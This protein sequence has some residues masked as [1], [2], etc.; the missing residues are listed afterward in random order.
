MS[1]AG[2]A[3]HISNCFASAGSRV[4]LCVYTGFLWYLRTYI[5]FGMP[6]PPTFAYCSELFVNGTEV[7]KR[8]IGRIT[9]NEMSVISFWCLSSG[10]PR[11]SCETV[12]V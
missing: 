7:E 1:P 10:F 6:T 12:V 3:Q 5:F 8:V 11:R 9:E 4:V 2:L